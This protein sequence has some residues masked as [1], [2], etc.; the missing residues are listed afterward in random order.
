MKKA[1]FTT[2][3]FQLH[4]TTY[5]LIIQYDH[6][7]ATGNWIIAFI[8]PPWL[9]YF[10]SPPFS[11]SLTCCSES[12]QDSVVQSFPRDIWQCFGGETSVLQPREWSPI[13]N[14]IYWNVQKYYF[15]FK[16]FSKKNKISINYQEQT[17]HSSNKFFIFVKIKLPH[18]IWYLLKTNIICTIQCMPCPACRYF[19]NTNTNIWFWF[20]ID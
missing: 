10:S 18:L 15:L 8:F 6:T 2:T 9:C 20:Q 11:L 3:L 19:T 14:T 4:Y 17:L 1:I 7:G 13:W 5:L 16:I 12:D